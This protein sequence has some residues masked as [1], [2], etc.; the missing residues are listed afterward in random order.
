MGNVFVTGNVVG[1]ISAFRN[2]VMVVEV[3][4]EVVSTVSVE[5][6][7]P[8]FVGAADGSAEKVGKFR[9]VRRLL[10]DGIVIGD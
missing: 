7:N 2:G 8:A 10:I 5:Q 1:D 3:G 9:L 4:E 6:D